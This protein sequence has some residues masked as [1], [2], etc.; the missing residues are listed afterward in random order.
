[1]QT[2]RHD[3]RSAKELRQDAYPDAGDQLDAIYK[4]AVALKAAG[5]ELPKETLDWM[6]RCKQ[7]KDQY[8]LDQEK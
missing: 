1:M 6:S 8:P 3:I 4:M 2:L 7:V 5:I